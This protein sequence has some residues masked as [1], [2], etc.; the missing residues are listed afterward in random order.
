MP[1][2][3]VTPVD[4]TGAGDCF[5]GY[6][7][8]A[9]AADRPVKQALAEASAAAA[10]QVTRPGASAAIPDRGEMNVYLAANQ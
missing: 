1:A 7:L 6:L 10:I 2:F 9:I 8:A 4:T 3:S 5:F